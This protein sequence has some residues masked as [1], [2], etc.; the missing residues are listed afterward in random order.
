MKHA[1]GFTL[2]EVLIAMA[3]F[4]LMLSL[5]FSTLHMAARAWE[6]G[7]PQA[8]ALSG[9][10]VVER[11]LRDQL[12]SAQSWSGDEA[13]SPLDGRPDSISFTT[14][15]PFQAGVRGP[16]RITLALKNH[17]LEVKITPVQGEMPASET[18]LRQLVLLD[19]V[20]KVKFRYFL[21]DTWQENW[22]GDQ[23]LPDLVEMTLETEGGYTWPPLLIDFR[24]G[25]STAPR[26]GFGRKPFQF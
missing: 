8:S 7:E 3:L 18:G 9:R 24:Y 5:V 20:R 23:G 14:F 22:E 10:L 19:R 13:I 26:P 12:A 21:V 2:L 16:Q 17:D 1:Q 4:G 11:F 15:L 6:S 25:I